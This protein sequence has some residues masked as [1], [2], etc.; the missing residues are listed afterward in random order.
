MALQE[1]ARHALSRNVPCQWK[2]WFDVQ[3]LH[4]NVTVACADGVVELLPNVTA[5]AI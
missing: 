1:L 2:Q 5:R 4:R 3:G